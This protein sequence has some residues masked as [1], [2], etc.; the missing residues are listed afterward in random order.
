[1][2][3]KAPL[4]LITLAIAILLN[5][6]LSAQPTRSERAIKHLNQLHRGTLVICLR[7]N[8]ILIDS[9]LAKGD[10]TS[11]IIVKAE[12]VKKNAGVI[13]AFN[14]YYTF[15][16][17]LFF[18]SDDSKLVKNQ[19]YNHPIFLNK[20]L[21]KDSTVQPTGIVYIGEI[22]K[23]QRGVTA[24][25]LN[26]ANWEQLRRPLPYMIKKFEGS[27]LERT[28]IEV[29]EIFNYQL[30]NYLKVTQGF[31]QKRNSRKEINKEG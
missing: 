15:S 12:Q 20:E 6:S 27:F 30:R 3:R 1:M 14:N 17:F 7:T 24:L 28:N 16:D 26:D 31:G 18:Y 8:K 13:K 5:V 21:E 19:E 25:V 11:A 2:F 10:T 9:Y 29:V 22:G 23:T 4:R